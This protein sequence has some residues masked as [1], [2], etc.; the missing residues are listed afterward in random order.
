MR[1]HL[2]IC[3][4]PCRYIPAAVIPEA[5]DPSSAAALCCDVA[6][7]SAERS[8]RLWKAR[9]VCDAGDGHSPRPAQPKAAGQTASP[10]ESESESVG[11]MWDRVTKLDGLRTAEPES[12]CRETSLFC[13]RLQIILELCKNEE[14]ANM[15]TVQPHLTRIRPPGH[16]GVSK[17]SFCIK[18]IP[19]GALM[20]FYLIDQ[21]SVIKLITNYIDNQ[22]IS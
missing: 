12:C 16:T 8:P 13:L 7:G 4:C 15:L 11:C 10:A 19:D 20:C 18:I 6:G 9:W 21:L 1:R 3:P 17:Q 22:F 2:F 14:T 5:A